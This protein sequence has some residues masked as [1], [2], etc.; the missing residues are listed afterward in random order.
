MNLYVVRRTDLREDLPMFRMLAI[1][2]QSK[3]NLGT[4]FIGVWTCFSSPTS[5]SSCV[6]HCAH[7]L[8]LNYRTQEFLS[9][10]IL[11]FLTSSLE[12]FI[13][14]AV[15]EQKGMNFVNVYMLLNKW[16][17]KFC[18]WWN[19]FVNYKCNLSHDENINNLSIN[20]RSFH[21]SCL[22]HMYKGLWRLL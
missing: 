1:K 13:D 21:L 4:L 20:S 6:T 3:N 14:S 10:N 22:R 2:S 18:D 7:V 15:S 19:K 11:K 8:A 16:K 9:R 5:G 17:I 12:V